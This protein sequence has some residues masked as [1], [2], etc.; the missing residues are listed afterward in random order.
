VP[1]FGGLPFSG[2]SH[3]TPLVD[4]SWQAGV[5]SQMAAM[6]EQVTRFSQAANR[7]AQSDATRLGRLLTRLNQPGYHVAHL[8][9]DI[10]T[11]AQAYNN[12]PTD[13]ESNRNSAELFEYARTVA[14]VSDPNTPGSTFVPPHLLIPSTSQYLRSLH[15]TPASKTELDLVSRARGIAKLQKDL[16]HAS[17]GPLFAVNP[18]PPPAFTPFTTP[19]QPFAYPKHPPAYPSPFAPAPYAPPYQAHPLP[20]SPVQ[21]PRSRP[22]LS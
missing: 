1:A 18:F 7:R 12:N 13:I 9:A 10:N 5:E 21:Q 8:P 14:R 4:V 15:D 11:V 3:P 20:P 19:A 16:T 2:P 17:S 6:K 22:V